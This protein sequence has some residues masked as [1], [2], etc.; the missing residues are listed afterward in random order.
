MTDI[1]ERLHRY[2]DDMSD[3]AYVIERLRRALKEITEGPRGAMSE[4]RWLEHV[5]SL[6]WEALNDQS[7]DEQEAGQD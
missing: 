2:R 7:T 1:V 6:A 5:N 4:K 3:A